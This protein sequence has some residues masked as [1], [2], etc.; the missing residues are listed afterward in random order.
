MLR[1]GSYEDLYVAD[2]SK[3]KYLEYLQPVAKEDREHV[4]EP[5]SSL[6]ALPNITD[7]TWTFLN[8]PSPDLSHPDI[9]LYQI[10]ELTNRLQERFITHHAEKRE[11][12]RQFRPELLTPENHEMQVTGTEPEVREHMNQIATTRVRL[13]W[14][15]IIRWQ[16]YYI[17]DTIVIHPENAHGRSVGS[18]WNKPDNPVSQAVNP[19]IRPYTH[20]VYRYHQFPI[21][22]VRMPHRRMSGMY[23]YRMLLPTDVDKSLFE[24]VSKAYQYNDNET[25]STRDLKR[26]YRGLHAKQNQVNYKNYFSPIQE[27]R[28]HARQQSSHTHGN[29]TV[30]VESFLDAYMS[31]PSES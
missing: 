21:I 16:Q 31:K 15:Q 1:N 18:G 30:D 24:L 2:P 4:G 14:S 23:Y 12:A 7:V 27:A 9:R 26:K 25:I 3:P 19:R 29:N 20:L 10:W 28:R 6:A 17:D 22:V 5:Q 8:P 11:Y 13:L